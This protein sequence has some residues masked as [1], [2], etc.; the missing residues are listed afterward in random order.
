MIFGKRLKEARQK[1]GLTQEELA[2]Q[3]GVAKSTL[4]GYEKG[5]R[6]PDFFKIKK[7]TEILD[8]NADYLLGINPANDLKVKSEDT[9]SAELIAEIYDN[10]KELSEEELLYILDMVKTYKKHMVSPHKNQ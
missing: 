7:L 1:K 9:K 5:N 6:E 4:T 10:A 8:V 3:I 2:K